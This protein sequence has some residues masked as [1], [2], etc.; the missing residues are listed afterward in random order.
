MRALL[1]TVIGLAS[2]GALAAPKHDRAALQREVAAAVEA[3]DWC[4]ALHYTELLEQLGHEAR[5]VFNAAELARAAGDL[6]T[7]RAYYREVGESDPGYAKAPLARQAADEVSAQIAARG[8][9]TR[10]LPPLARCGDGAVEASEVCDDGN[11]DAGDA[12][13]ADCSRAPRCG[14]S[15]VDLPEMC[16]DGNLVAGDNCSPQCRPEVQGSVRPPPVVPPDPPASTTELVVHAADAT[17]NDAGEV[18]PLVEGPAPPPTPGT[19]VLAAG[20]V[21]AGVIGTTAG[22]VSVI[23]GPLPLVRYLWGSSALDDAAT[24]ARRAPDDTRYLA[25]LRGGSTL[26]AGLRLDAEQWNGTGRV[27][28]TLGV[29]MLAV[30]IAGIVGGALLARGAPDESAPP[31]VE[32]VP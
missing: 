11:T 31:P 10:C 32:L 25:E 8:P 2:V 27:L 13:V 21:G 3:R 15:I 22:V 18:V 26:D 30:G 9:G 24:R 5:L 16:D 14:D 12:C 28:T 19:R 6:I 23:I 4:R 7:A 1:L 17:P 29:S 20:M